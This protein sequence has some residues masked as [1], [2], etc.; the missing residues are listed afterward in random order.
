MLDLAKRIQE[1]TNAEIRFS[2]GH[3]GDS[4]RRLPDLEDNNL[5]EWRASTTLEEGLSRLIAML[6]S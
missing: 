5:I 4:L 6:G 2:P 1:L 3:P